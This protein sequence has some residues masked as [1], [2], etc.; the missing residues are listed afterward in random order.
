[1]KRMTIDAA[2][3]Q[4]TMEDLTQAEMDAKATQTAAAEAVMYQTKRARNYP[5]IGDQLDAILKLLEQFRADGNKLSPEM[6]TVISQWLAVKAAYP[7][8]N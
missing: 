6:E 1:M 2:T 4:A 8:P 3:G 5:P 7:K